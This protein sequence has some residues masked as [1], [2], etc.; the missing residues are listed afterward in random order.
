[1]CW[2]NR[3]LQWRT[4]HARDDNLPSPLCIRLTL[5][6]WRNQILWANSLL[7]QVLIL[8]NKL[9]TIV[10]K[11]VDVNIEQFEQRRNSENGVSSKWLRMQNFCVF[12]RRNRSSLHGRLIV[13]GKC[14]PVPGDDASDAIDIQSSCDVTDLWF[15]ITTCAR[16]LIYS[17]LL[18]YKIIITWW[19][20]IKVAVV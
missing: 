1:M 8:S 4:A 13:R 9:M 12:P 5:R 17:S 11:C 20:G 14:R 7:F 6:F 2:Q 16:S 19:R 18:W 10:Q 15:V 3:H